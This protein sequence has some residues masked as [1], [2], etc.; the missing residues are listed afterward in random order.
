[1]SSPIFGAKDA[2][3]VESLMES[4]RNS[5]DLENLD[6]MFGDFNKGKPHNVPENTALFLYR[7]QQ[8]VSG[9]E[10]L[11]WLADVTVRNYDPMPQDSM[12]QMAIFAISKQKD[13]QLMMMICQAIADGEKLE[14]QK[15][16][17]NEKFT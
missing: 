13:L 9:R 15:D 4:V 17:E 1:M 2:M 5:T 16:P 14:K 12:E 11:E 3:S 8:T 7:M 6:A 10:F